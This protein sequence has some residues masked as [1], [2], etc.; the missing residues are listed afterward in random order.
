LSYNDAAAWAAGPDHVYRL[1]ARVAVE[2]M[3]K[4]YLGVRRRSRSAAM[5][6]A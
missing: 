3:P 1:L 5:M 4:T 2:L 6:P